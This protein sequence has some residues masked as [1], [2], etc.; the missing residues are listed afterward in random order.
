MDDSMGAEVFVALLDLF[1]PLPPPV[2]EETWVGPSSGPVWLI[3]SENPDLDAP[4]DEENISSE[5]PSLEVLVANILPVADA[6]ARDVLVLGPPKAEV[7][8]PSIVLCNSPEPSTGPD[9]LPNSSS[10]TFTVP[11]NDP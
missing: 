7:L 9:E 5:E 1:V 8:A 11:V 10:V 6:E 4:S 2:E 3:T